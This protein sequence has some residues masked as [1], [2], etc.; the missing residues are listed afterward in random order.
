M[1]DEIKKIR[2]DFTG[3]SE[4]T[5]EKLTFFGVLNRFYI[6]DIEGTK[7]RVGGISRNWNAE[8]TRKANKNNYE[9]VIFPRI[10]NIP[11]EEMTKDDFDE[12]IQSIIRAGGRGG[13]AYSAP[14]I[15]A[16]KRLL[17]GV[18]EEAAKQGICEDVLFGSSYAIP[19]SEPH[20]KSLEKELVRLRK[21][22]TVKEEFLI[23]QHVLRDAAQSGQQIGLALMF[24]MGL[25]NEEACGLDFG[26]IKPMQYHPKCSCLWVYKSTKRGTN[27]LQASGKTRN[28]A[29]LLPIP[30]VLLELLEERRRLIQEKVDA[31]Q[32]ILPK[33]ATIDQLP[34]VC[35]DFDYLE[36]CNSKQLTA[37]GRQILKAVKIAENELA[38]IDIELEENRLAEDG[39]YEKDPT[40]YLCR[41]NLGTHLY[42]MGLTEA[43]IQYIMGHD[44]E[45]PYE[46]RNDFTNEDKLYQIKRKMELRPLVNTME[47]P[48]VTEL[49]A[50]GG[51]S[52]SFQNCS[53]QE[54]HIVSDGPIHLKL[55]AVARLPQ[56]DIHIDAAYQNSTLQFGELSSLAG[57][58][59]PDSRTVNITRDY[60]YVYKSTLSKIKASG[61]GSSASDLEDDD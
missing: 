48:A 45:D 53:S 49:K 58:A 3:Y 11:L 40:V 39:V 56:N 37:A 41:R 27:Q 20:T 46:S 43:E 7:S 35:S 6:Y 36:R 60:H 30:G 55:Q 59:T 54:T 25:R 22:F 51:A 2:P 34:I 47:P 12:I 31:G 13:R 57:P 21:S 1:T 23:S 29:R 8:S 42:I 33:N 17:K 24:C 14:R 15:Q 18:T 28:M 26:D 19:E 4:T 61:R 5:D 52:V 50:G 44:I 32:I 10:P 16:F 9:K 38:Y